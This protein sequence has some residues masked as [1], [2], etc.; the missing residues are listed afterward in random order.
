MRSPA[1]GEATQPRVAAEPSSSHTTNVHSVSVSE[2]GSPE[3]KTSSSTWHE[4]HT[5]GAVGLEARRVYMYSMG[6]RRTKHYSCGRRRYVNVQ[7]YVY[8]SVRACVDAASGGMVHVRQSADFGRVCR[9][10]EHVR[11]SVRSYGR[12]CYDHSY[13]RWAYF[14]G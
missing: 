14:F 11:P 2:M 8:G 10:S 1:A 13:S 4:Q 3:C 7:L 5:A 6:R 12:K 9:L